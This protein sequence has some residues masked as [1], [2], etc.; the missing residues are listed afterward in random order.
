MS[1][2]SRALALVV[3]FA[4]VAAMSSHVARAQ[5]ARALEIRY[6]PTARAQIAIWVESADGTYMGT[7]KLTEAVAYRGIGNRPGALQMNSGFR[8]PYGRREGVLPVWAHRRVSAPGAESFRRVI[9]QNRGEGLASRLVNDYS[10]DNYFCLSFNQAA[11]QDLDA[12]SCAS[13]FNSDK[14]RFI[15]STD[16]QNGYSEPWQTS[17]GVEGSRVLTFDALYPPRRDILMRTGFDH[18]DVDSFRSE[19][20]RVMPELDA[21]TMATAPASQPQLIQFDVPDAWP[22]GDYILYVEANTERDHN[23]SWST[24]A[25]PTPQSEMYDYWAKAY[26]FAYRGQPSIVYSLPFTLS[27]DGGTYSTS[28]PSGY[29]DVQGLDGTLR[30]ID[31][32]ITDAPQASPGSGADRLRAVGSTPRVVMSVLD[33][34]ICAGEDPPPE[35]SLG[36]TTDAECPTNFLC[37]S[38]NTCVGRCEALAAPNAAE[39]FA[40]TNHPDE[41]HSHEWAVL[42][43]RAPTSRREV[44]RYEVR[45]SPEPITNDAEF[46]AAVNAKAAMLELQAVSVCDASNMDITCPAPGSEVS[47]DIGWLDRLSTYH[48]AIRAFDECGVASPIVSSM[49]E[50]TDINFTTVSPCFVATAAYGSPMADDVQTLRDF[51]DRRLMTNAPGRAFVSAYYAVGPYLADFIREDDDR[52]ALARTL[53]SPLVAMA[54]A[55]DD[56]RDAE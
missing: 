37:G 2:S 50:T 11:A 54:R 42:D 46:A 23:A 36:C 48:V 20:L 27:T 29:A 45:V 4:L 33:T 51:R 41:K 1:F 13:V 21:I 43:F 28:T 10:R 8:W 14:G 5:P 38:A 18:V 53:L 30:P 26:G 6:T 22:N 31:A 15:T 16:V 3:T 49:V 32:S 34:A 24:A 47:V 56:T 25:H 39:G 52:R 7:I 55:L 19:A 35:C 17:P 40:V 44:R 9:F 12:V